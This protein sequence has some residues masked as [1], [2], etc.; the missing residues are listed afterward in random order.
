[1]MSTQ[2]EPP[3]TGDI[4]VQAAYDTVERLNSVPDLEKQGA[5]TPGSWAL[6]SQPPLCNP[7]QQGPE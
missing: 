5:R 2:S 7:V 3:D 1:M 4:Q 6:N